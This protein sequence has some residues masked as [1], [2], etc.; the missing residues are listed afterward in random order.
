MSKPVKKHLSV[1]AAVVCAA[2]LAMPLHFLWPTPVQSAD[3]QHK[4][5]SARV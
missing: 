1:T 4:S 3:I 2:A 5:L